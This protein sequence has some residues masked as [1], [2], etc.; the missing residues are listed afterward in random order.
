MK[1]KPIDNS[2]SIERLTELVKGY[3]GSQIASL[4]NAAAMSAIREH[5]TNNRAYQMHPQ[6]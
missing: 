5:I 2:V 1:K 6:K 4:V 3:S